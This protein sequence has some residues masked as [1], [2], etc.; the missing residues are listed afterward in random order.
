[1][2]KFS[3]GTHKT[4]E[5]EGYLKTCGEKGLRQGCII[6]RGHGRL[7]QETAK[8]RKTWCQLAEGPCPFT[9]KKRKKI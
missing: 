5:I 1:M 7:L 4:N 6:W 9:G 2:K 8:D 3:F